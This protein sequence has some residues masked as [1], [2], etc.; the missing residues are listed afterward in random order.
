[1]H[2]QSIF[3]G[4]TPELRGIRLDV[5]ITE[6]IDRSTEEGESAECRIYDVEAQNREVADLPRRGRF[7]QA[8]L[9]SKGLESGE[10]S[11]SIEMV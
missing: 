6:K 11:W 5:E 1:M 8:K 2:A 4:D 10:K 3:Q 7:Y 9:D